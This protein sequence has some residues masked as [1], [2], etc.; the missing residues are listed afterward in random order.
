MG[1]IIEPKEVDFY[2][3]DNPW[4]EAEKHEFSELIKR[5][6]EKLNKKPHR[7]SKRKTEKH[8]A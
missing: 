5:Q 8:I 1:L 2:V 7:I 6:K 3:I 4:S